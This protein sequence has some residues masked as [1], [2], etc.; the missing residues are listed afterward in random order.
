MG[1]GLIVCGWIGAAAVPF[2]FNTTFQKS[3]LNPPGS[4]HALIEHLIPVAMVGASAGFA[5]AVAIV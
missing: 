3:K 4:F 1:M 2:T 5:R